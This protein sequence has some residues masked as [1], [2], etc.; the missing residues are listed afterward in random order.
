[1]SVDKDP[2]SG[3]DFYQ[4][5]LFKEGSK[6]KQPGKGQLKTTFKNITL[7]T[8]MQDKILSYVNKNEYFCED[9][10]SEDIIEQDHE[11]FDYNDQ[12]IDENDERYEYNDYPDE[13]VDC[14]L[15]NPDS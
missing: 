7:D 6:G 8:Q 2:F 15:S 13:M 12:D 3:Y 14:L 4:A 9:S 10:D 11:P 5:S 1:M